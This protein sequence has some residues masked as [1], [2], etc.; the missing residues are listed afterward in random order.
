[1]K[2][3]D[4][5]DA[6]KVVRRVRGQ[7]YSCWLTS[8]TGAVRYPE[9]Q[10]TVP[11]IGWGPLATFEDMDSARSFLPDIEWQAVDPIEIWRIK[12]RVVRPPMTTGLFLLWA[13][14]RR[15]GVR[16]VPRGTILAD[17]VYLTER[18]SC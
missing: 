18:A 7:L 17:A 9:H 12:A 1:M 8:S 3:G 14:H 5:V 15:T 10:W 13:L 4:I 2:T 11:R 6:V 16:T